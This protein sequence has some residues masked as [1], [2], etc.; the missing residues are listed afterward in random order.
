VS[1]ERHFH[2]GHMKRK[3]IISVALIL[4]IFLFTSTSFAG[5]WNGWIYQNPYPTDQALKGVEFV[6]PD[7]GW[8]V[9]SVGTILYTEDSGKTWELQESGT[10]NGLNSIFF[11]DEK[12][13]WI[14]GEEG[15][16]L[17]TENG[18]KDWVWQEIGS[19]YDLKKIRFVDSKEGWISALA[20]D[21]NN[22][23]NVIFHTKDGGKNWGEESFNLGKI[24]A[25]FFI[26]SKT[27]WILG[28]GKVFKTI[29]GGKKWQASSLPIDSK[30]QISFFSGDIH[31][32]NEKVGWVLINITIKSTSA[33]S[34][35]NQIF[36]TV[37]GGKTWKFQFSGGRRSSKRIEDSRG[38]KVE[39][40]GSIFF[41]NTLI[42][43][44]DKRG[45]VLGDTIFCTDD[46][47]TTWTEK[48]GAKPGEPKTINGFPVGFGTGDFINNNEAW[49]IGGR[50]IMKTENSGKDW[51][52]KTKGWVGWGGWGED[53]SYINFID[54]KNGWAVRRGENLNR[55]IGASGIIIKTSDGGDNWEIQKKFTNP[56]NLRS[57]FI[58]HSTGWV[59]GRE[60]EE[61]SASQKAIIIHTKDGGKTW[62][63][64]YNK[65]SKFELRDVYFTD[66][67]TGWVSGD[68]GIILHTTDGGKTWVIQKSGQRKKTRWDLHSIFFS[69]N[70]RG[71]IIGGV[72]T[73]DFDF[74]E[75][76]VLYTEDGGENWRIQWANENAVH[77]FFL[78][79]QK[80]WITGDL[81][82][83]YTENGGEHWIEKKLPKE[84]LD[85]FKEGDYLSSPY[86]ID[87]NRGWIHLGN[88]SVSA[89][90]VQDLLI[91]EDGGNTWKRV[92]SGLHRYP[93]RPFNSEGRT[94]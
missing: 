8:V 75:G 66:V 35:T 51:S 76:I 73:A 79:S 48:L 80:A 25:I 24:G 56:I 31:F 6:S 2:G 93:W 20:N 16:I 81:K 42:F 74:I 84:I 5:S 46:G 72:Y 22:W 4:S 27:G 36:H 11:F 3:V 61:R 62:E 17:S 90:T 86:F 77:P 40:E 87:Q 63:V 58:D 1:F 83:F 26:D 21:S 94:N 54:S 50:L 88:E 49:V 30:V 18:G 45:C 12:T 13:G 92:K 91:T 10:T 19:K 65:K 64:Q 82:L 28:E 41:L 33:T 7:K 70:K 47:G 43:A 32:V 55:E 44:N 37:D 29:D 9:G 71:W 57:F 39:S 38:F 68:D 15:N 59:V 60:G 34:Q 52:I 53:P 85:T 14:V 67:N 23:K 89:F 78:N 69:D